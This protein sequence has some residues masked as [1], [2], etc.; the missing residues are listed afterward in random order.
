MRKTLFISG[1]S[2]FLGA[3]LINSLPSYKKILGVRDDTKN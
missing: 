3:R 1:S 2:G